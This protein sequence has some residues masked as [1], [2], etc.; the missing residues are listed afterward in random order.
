MSDHAHVC[1]L[2]S[3]ADPHSRIPAQVTGCSTDSPVVPPH[4]PWVDMP[5]RYGVLKVT[6][7]LTHAATHDTDG[8]LAVDVPPF[9]LISTASR[10]TLRVSHS[11]FEVLCRRTS[12]AC[13]ELWPN[14][15]LKVRPH[16]A[17]QSVNPDFLV[18]TKQECIAA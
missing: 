11:C 14:R 18:K 4:R 10:Q 3:H 9:S 5:G 17:V 8:V 6:L 7:Q 13:D 16:F 1:F 2:A 12:A 15:A